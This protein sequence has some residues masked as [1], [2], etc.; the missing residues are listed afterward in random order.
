MPWKDLEEIKAKATKILGKDAKIPP[1]KGDFDKNFSDGAKLVDAYNKSREDLEDKI[2]ALENSI[3]GFINGLKQSA[4]V[5]E[6]D[7]FGLDPKKKDDAKKIK[8]AQQ[9]FSSFFSSELSSMTT[10][11][12]DIDELDKHVIQLGKYKSP[13]TR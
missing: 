11:T 10:K 8:Q 1:E 7:N 13:W 5:Y 3:S 12:K 4:A 9:M 6:K 2:L